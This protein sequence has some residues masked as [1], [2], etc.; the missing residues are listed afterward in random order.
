MLVD[1]LD[2]P[3]EGRLLRATLILIILV[4]ASG[5]LF[6]AMTGARER[7]EEIEEAHEHALRLQSLVVSRPADLAGEQAEPEASPADAEA[8]DSQP[9]PS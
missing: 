5:L 9:D 4:L 6:G 3:E 2:P 7:E 8:G 1:P